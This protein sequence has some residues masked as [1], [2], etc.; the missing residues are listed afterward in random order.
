VPGKYQYAIRAQVMAVPFLN[1]RL[2]VGADTQ[3]KAFSHLKKLPL[4][5]E[6]PFIPEY[7]EE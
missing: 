3:K 6:M 5:L 7:L 4:S 2:I 1:S